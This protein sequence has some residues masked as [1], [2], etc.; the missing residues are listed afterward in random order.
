MLRPA[1]YPRGNVRRRTYQHAQQ[2]KHRLL[3]SI[4]RVQVP[5]IARPLPRGREVHRQRCLGTASDRTTE[6]AERAAQAQRDNPQRGG[7][8][9]RGDDEG[10]RESQGQRGEVR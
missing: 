3:A 7:G 5:N 8:V 2:R 10:V 6:R 4:L 9:V 1:Q